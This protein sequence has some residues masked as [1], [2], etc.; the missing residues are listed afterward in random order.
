MQVFCIIYYVLSF[1]QTIPCVA[2]LLRTKKSGDYSLL[3]R[4]CQYVALIFFT[5][6]IFTNPTSAVVTKVI[7]VVDL[8]LLTLENVP[9]L[10]YFRRKDD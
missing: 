4:L 7:G 6:Y 10:K 3:N 1:A 5:I 9:I 8:G 2:K